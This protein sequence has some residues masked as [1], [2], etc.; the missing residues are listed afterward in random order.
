MYLFPGNFT[1]SY[2]NMT[3]KNIMGLQWTLQYCKTVPYVFK[4]DDDIMLNIP[5]I[6]NFLPP[7]T[8]RSIIGSL[9]DNTIVIR[10]HFKPPY[11]TKWSLPKSLYPFNNFPQFVYGAGYVITGDIIA[12]LYETSKFIPYI[13][14]DDMFVTGI[15]RHVIGAQVL[16]FYGLFKF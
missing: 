13:F 2:K 10:K 11:N 1:E 9:V 8:Q 7:K 6:I 3:Y 4:C 12:E 14:I 15:L 5:N 16:R